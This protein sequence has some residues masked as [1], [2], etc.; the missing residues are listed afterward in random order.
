VPQGIIGVCR[1]ITRVLSVFILG[2]AA[3]FSADPPI[4]PLGVCEVLHD[5]PALEGKN[6]AVIGRYSFRENGRWVAEP[7][8]APP[9]TVPPQLWLVEDLKGGPK[10]P[11]NFEL[12]GV[13]LNRKFVELQRRAPL[14][15]FRFGTPDYDRWAVIY[16]RVEAR[17]GEDSKR[18]AANLIIRGD[19][20]IIVLTPE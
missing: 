6:V 10:P 12:D 5:L 11:G 17:K 2:S 3:T 4:L 13:A 7:S 19:G 1:S 20:V 18:A 16:G 15:K 8:C 14:G 9:V